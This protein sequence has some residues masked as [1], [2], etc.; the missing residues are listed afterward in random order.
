MQGNSSPLI[1]VGAVLVAIVLIVA[2]FFVFNKGTNSA[3]SALSSYSTEDVSS[4][5]TQYEMFNGTQKGSNVSTMINKLIASANTNKDNLDRVPSVTIDKVNKN[6]DNVENAIKP[7]SSSDIENYI[8]NLGNI[9]S[10]IETKHDY[11]VTINY[12]TSGYISEFSI[13]Y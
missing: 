4:F 11:E 3:K 7:K 6:N 1:A 9:K 13:K 2:I 12:G 8:I 5:N 10:K